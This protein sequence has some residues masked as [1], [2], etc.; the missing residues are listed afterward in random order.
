MDQHNLPLTP[1]PRK[2]PA[3]LMKVVRT[4]REHGSLSTFELTQLSKVLPVSTA[5]SQLRNE[6][7]YDIRCSERS[8]GGNRVWF[9]TLHESRS[10]GAAL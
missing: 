7:G 8:V 10:V 3:R 1:P 6:H 5:I 9:Y 4:L 2:A